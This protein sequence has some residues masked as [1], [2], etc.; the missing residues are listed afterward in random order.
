M[1]RAWWR[2]REDSI[3]GLVR[4][5]RRAR[6]RSLTLRARAGVSHCRRAT[7]EARTARA[8]SRSP[9][10]LALES[11]VGPRAQGSER[12]APGPESPTAR[13]RVK[14]SDC[15]R[16]RPGSRNARVARLG[17][18]RRSTSVVRR[19][20]AGPATQVDQRRAPQ[21]GPR[22]RTTGVARLGPARDTGR[23][24]SCGTSMPTE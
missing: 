13:A 17:P 1:I 20:S 9:V 10:L 16:S 12:S 23:P 15:A 21:I 8:R 11:S 6:G 5:P 22:H 3:R 24:A 14:V 2:E 18:R 19:R 4:R 7:R